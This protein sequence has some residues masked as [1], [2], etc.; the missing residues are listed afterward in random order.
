MNSVKD[1]FLKL[2]KRELKGCD[3]ALIQDALSDAEEHITTAVENLMANDPQISYEDAFK[4]ACEDYGEISEITSEYKKMENKYE[5]VFHSNENNSR[6]G[7]AKFFLIISDPRAWTSTL[8]MILSIITG[9]IYF[10]W[11][12]CGL[13]ISIPFLIFIIGLP[14]AGI[15]LLSVR[16][17][18]LLEGRLV[19][20]LLGV[21]MPRK[22]MFM[23]KER[24]W[25]HK[26]KDL[27]K[28]GITWKAMIYMILQMPLGIIYFSLIITLFTVSIA[29][30]AAPILELIF[31]LPMEINGHD[32]YTSKW[33]LPL[34]P[35][36]GAF[37]L[38]LSLHLSKFIGKIHGLFAKFMLV[39]K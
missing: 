2:I 20:L 11:V 36:V 23:D 1:D 39:K 26:F 13:S 35:F 31:H 7:I 10:T 27:I 14:L 4:E 24:G 28:A 16:G 33:L 12:I 18:A 15:F 32:Q 29:L 21:R 17:I 37:L 34:V 8:Y 25:W 5:P 22:P 3:K 9:I 19:E 38:L 30:I 6:S